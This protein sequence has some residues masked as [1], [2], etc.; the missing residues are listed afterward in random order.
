[1][2][3]FAKTD[4]AISC[5]HG[6]GIKMSHCSIFTA[7]ALSEFGATVCVCGGGGGGK[8]SENMVRWVGGGGGGFMYVFELITCTAGAE[9][10]PIFW[11]LQMRTIGWGGGGGRWGE[12]FTRPSGY[13]RVVEFMYLVFTRMPGERVP[14]GNSGLWLLFFVFVGLYTYTSRKSNT[15]I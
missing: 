3:L 11:L 5:V 2:N 10:P 13:Q 9:V 6:N 14:V 7:Q 12:C 4:P 15:Q 8:W 1:M